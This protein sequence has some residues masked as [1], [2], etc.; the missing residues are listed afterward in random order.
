MSSSFNCKLS[1]FWALQG[2]KHFLLIQ[3]KQRN[4]YCW[5]WWFSLRLDI[6]T[7]VNEYFLWL[8]DFRVQAMVFCFVTKFKQCFVTKSCPTSLFFPWDSPGKN[9]EVGCH[10]LLQET[11]LLMLRVVAGCQVKSAFDV[12]S[13]IGGKNSLPKVK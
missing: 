1:L 13:C 3:T 8:I 5:D 4:W 10:F 7:A 12:T 11:H 2:Q 6:Q 9:G